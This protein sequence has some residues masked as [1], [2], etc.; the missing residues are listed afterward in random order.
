MK[1]P[2]FT[3]GLDAALCVLGGKWKPLI[4]FHLAHGTRRYGE[5]RRAVGGVTDKVLIQQLKELQADG[6]I[7]RR[8]FQEIPPKVEYSLTAFGQTLGKA[9]A[10]LCAWGTRHSDAVQKIVARRNSG[11]ASAA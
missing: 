4:L 11:R 5:L 8:D 1:K 2:A 6:I 9:L 3:C 7:D 10:P